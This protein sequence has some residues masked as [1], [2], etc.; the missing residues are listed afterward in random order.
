MDQGKVVKTVRTML[1]TYDVTDQHYCIN[2]KG[3]PL[4]EVFKEVEDRL[5]KEHPEL[6]DDCDHFSIF[7]T[8]RDQAFPT[9]YSWIKVFYVEGG[10]EGWWVHVEVNN[11]LLFLGKT[12][13]EGE[14]G[15][16]WAERMVCALGRIF[17]GPEPGVIVKARYMMVSPPESP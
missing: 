6:K 9:S 7:P 3:N 11:E 16:S 17:Y 15:I 2:E 5:W 1:T 14:A 10:S 8:V 13:R 4:R 12:L